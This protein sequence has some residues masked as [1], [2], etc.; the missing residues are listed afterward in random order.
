MPDEDIFI[1]YRDSVKSIIITHIFSYAG[2]FGLERFWRRIA[3]Y[4]GKQSSSFCSFQLI[5]TT[6]AICFS[7]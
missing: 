4:Q 6:T 2:W 3:S 1:C 7:S 5:V